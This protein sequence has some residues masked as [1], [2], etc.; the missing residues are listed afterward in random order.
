MPRNI[1]A[2]KNVPRISKNVTQQL[3]LIKQSFFLNDR[4]HKK[5]FSQ[6]LKVGTKIMGTFF[7]I[8][9]CSLISQGKK[10]DLVML[11]L[12]KEIFPSPEYPDFGSKFQKFGK[13]ISTYFYV[14]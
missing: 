13:L 1:A 5:M 12:S 7:K 4:K 14:V 8:L 10:N 2:A 6:D 11:E 9:Y 3:K